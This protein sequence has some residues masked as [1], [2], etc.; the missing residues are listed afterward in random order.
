MTPGLEGQ[1][2][3]P[4][5][6]PLDSIE[7][8][9]ALGTTSKTP[10][11]LQA[12]LAANES[13][14]WDESV[15]IVEALCQ[16]VQGDVPRAIP[17]AKEIFLTGVGSVTVRS[18]AGTP[19]PVEAGRRLV[20]LLGK[21][22]VP[23]PLRLFAS[24]AVRPEQHASLEEFQ[25][26]LEYF[27]RP[28]GRERIV[29]VFERSARQLA[30]GPLLPEDEAKAPEISQKTARNV[31]SRQ[32]VRK[33]LIAA[34]AFVAVALA[35]SVAYVAWLEISR[36]PVVASAA[37]D[38]PVEQ[39]RP[40]RRPTGRG[41]SRTRPTA[42][43][44]P[45]A[46]EPADAAPRTAGA[47]ADRADTWSRGEVDP[48]TAAGQSATSTLP[49]AADTTGDGTFPAEASSAAPAGVRETLGQPVDA[50]RVYSSSDEGVVPATLV[51]QQLLPP[52][53]GAASRLRPLQMELVVSAEGAV[54]SARFL[55][56]PQRMTDMMLL[57]N[58]KMW[59]FT[60]AL[61][62]GRPVRSRVVFSWHVAP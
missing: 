52:A 33:V 16:A 55:V 8:Q 46:L 1:S 34:V 38:V 4:A 30:A 15:S 17:S 32:W 51:R 44:V 24:Q 31:A 37:P 28:G 13:L 9:S 7:S 35:V 3:A 60:P 53:V 26:G 18:E 21:G 29:A 56:P 10:V 2:D 49:A 47:V 45:A 50:N 5:V 19:D 62:D 12:V 59:T 48:E 27:A 11:S 6:N 43:A 25:R 14:A 57:S 23:A 36:P 41:A 22:T 54:E 61:K 40:V 42:V 39:P 58:A 20:E